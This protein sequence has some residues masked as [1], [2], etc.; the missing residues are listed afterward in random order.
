MDNLLNQAMQSAASIALYCMFIA[1]VIPPSKH[2]KDIRFVVI[3]T[4]F[5]RLLM[6]FLPILN[7]ISQGYSIIISA[8]IAAGIG[9]IRYQDKNQCSED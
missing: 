1:L 5:I 9:A 4:I 2:H 8:C 6:T 7:Q 3:T